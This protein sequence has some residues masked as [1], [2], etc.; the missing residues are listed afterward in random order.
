[1]SEMVDNIKS[2]T[3]LIAR[4]QTLSDSLTKESISGS[5]EV[6]KTQKVI[7][8]ITEMS[9]RMGEVIKVIEAVASQTNLLA[10][11][12]AI[13]AAHAGDAGKGFAV[14]ANDVRELEK[15]TVTLER[16]LE[17]ENKV[18]ERARSK[19]LSLTTPLT[20]SRSVFIA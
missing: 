4:A 2:I 3:N 16:Y 15:L 18:P 1:M 10:M 12:A 19:E 17:S 8:G 9:K 5:A 11:N 14:V 7:N 13:E 20:F 6:I